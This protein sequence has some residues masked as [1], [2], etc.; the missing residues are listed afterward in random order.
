V[1]SATVSRVGSVGA[2]CLVVRA[3]GTP[4]H[5]VVRAVKMLRESGARIAG[6]VLNAL[7]GGNG[8]YYY[9]YHSP[10]YGG[11]EVYGAS[12]AIASKPETAKEPR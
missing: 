6:F 10:G 5:A 7:P 8:G 1:A 12:A 2:V 3:S 4:S 11:D 9:H